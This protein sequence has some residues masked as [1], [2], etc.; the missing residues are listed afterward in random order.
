MKKCPYCTGENQDKASVCLFCGKTF[1]PASVKKGKM[2]AGGCIV[3]S[4]LVIGF[5]IAMIVTIGGGS[6]KETP[7]SDSESAWYACR[8]FTEARLKAP[9]TADFE[10]YNASGVRRMN[11]NEWKVNLFVDAE[12]SFGAMLRNEF[13]CVVQNQGDSWKLVSIQ[14]K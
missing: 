5:V 4:L 7:I 14:E 2:T 6:N 12:N 10:H 11:A 3:V 13:E 8:Q 9:K 1:P